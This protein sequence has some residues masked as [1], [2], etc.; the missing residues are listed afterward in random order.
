MLPEFQMRM[1]MSYIEEVSNFT[2]TDGSN[3]MYPV[4]P[5]SMDDED[6][7]YDEDWGRGYD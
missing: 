7:E 2:Q 3:G 6:P 5:V 4:A 1:V